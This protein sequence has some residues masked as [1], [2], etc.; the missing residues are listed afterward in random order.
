M[1]FRSEFV[2]LGVAALCILAS[3]VGRITWPRSSDPVAPPTA[4]SGRLL[5][6]L[7]VGEFMALPSTQQVR[8]LNEWVEVIDT[9][10]GETSLWPLEVGAVWSF[11]RNLRQAALDSDSPAWASLV[12]GVLLA[13]DGTKFGEALFELSRPQ[14]PWEVELIGILVNDSPRSSVARLNQ[15]F[16]EA[17]RAVAGESKEIEDEVSDRDILS[18][19]VFLYNVLSLAPNLPLESGDR[20][21]EEFLEVFFEQ[22][23]PKVDGRGNAK[24]ARILSKPLPAGMSKADYARF[25]FLYVLGDPD[26]RFGEPAL[27]L[28]FE[29]EMMKHYRAERANPVRFGMSWQA[30]VRSG[31]EATTRDLHELKNEITKQLEGS[32]RELLV[33]GNPG[34]EVAERLYVRAVEA[35][36]ADSNYRSR[37]E[38][39]ARAGNAEAA[40]SLGVVF[41]DEG[42]EEEAVRWL[43]VA[44]Q[45]G[46][47][48]AMVLVARA[49]RVGL[50]VPQDRVEA[51]NWFRRA[52]YRGDIP[53]IVEYAETCSR[54]DGVK[55]SE[56]EATRWFERAANL[57]HR[58]ACMV[59]GARYMEG[60]GVTENVDTAVGWFAKAGELGDPQG[61]FMAGLA[62]L[63]G[64][65]VSTPDPAKGVAYLE[66]AADGGEAA[67]MAVLSEAYAKG[68]GVTR[69]ALLGQEWMTKA[70]ANGY[71][72]EIE[73]LPKR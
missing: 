50:G 41:N 19:V 38:L 73:W 37:L 32:L 17:Q 10:L 57:G 14:D 33:R 71:A 58:A 20:T 25:A 48:D 45:L 60:V 70:R 36:T 42:A 64:D 66:K 63:S 29:T 46:C 15:F 44:A 53:A 24:L 68:F 21:H 54:G 52:G 56:I 26:R 11:R 30:P 28:D 47:V 39:A 3:I 34:G 55:Q 22:F 4:K 1:K 67:A 61:N 2:I 6:D 49:H 5:E 8:Y 35:G 12:A 59:M 65:G 69:D 72:E 27:L 43:T 13:E 62:H 18:E 31:L 23:G 9:E 51:A 40:L 16:I 7:T